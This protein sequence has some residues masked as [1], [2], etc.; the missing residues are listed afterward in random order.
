[1]F[2]TLLSGSNTA[3]IMLGLTAHDP[4]SETRLWGEIHTHTPCTDDGSHVH[5]HIC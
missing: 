1:M 3:I 2:L 5:P 4:V